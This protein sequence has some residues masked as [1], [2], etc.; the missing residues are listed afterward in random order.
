MEHTKY[1][2]VFKGCS[3]MIE[4]KYIIKQNSIAINKKIILKDTHKALQK[5]EEIDQDIFL[6]SY[7]QM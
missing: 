6:I 1:M 7:L 3:I 4:I 2:L 5:L